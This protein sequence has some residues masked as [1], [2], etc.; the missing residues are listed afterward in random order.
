MV[1]HGAH[2]MRGTT[3]RHGHPIDLRLFTEG[4]QSVGGQLQ[5]RGYVVT[6]GVGEVLSQ[7]HTWMGS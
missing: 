6:V 1:S 5:G 4:V 7:G 2:A 3:D